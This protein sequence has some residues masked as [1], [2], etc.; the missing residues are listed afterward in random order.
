MNV[1]EEGQNG[2]RI[3]SFDLKAYIDIARP[4]H[5]FK[6]V[7]MLLG[8]VL[9]FFI[10]PDLVYDGWFTLLVL[11]LVSVCLVS[12]S[13]YVINEVLDAPRDALHPVKCRRPV[14]SGRVS[15]RVAYAEWLLLAALGLGIAWQINLPFFFSALCLWLAGMAYNIPPVRTKDVP[16]LDVLS[17]SIN[18]PLRLFMGWFVLIPHHFPPLSLVCAYW[19]VGAFFMGAKRFAEYRMI[20]NAEVAGKYRKS[21]KHYTADTLVISLFFYA[22]A[23][24]FFFGIFVIRYHLE[25]ILA[26]PVFA[27]FFAYYMKITFKKDSPVQN[28]ERLY[29]EKKFMIYLIG[30]CVIFVVLLFTRIEFMYELFNVISYKLKPLWSF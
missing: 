13:N 12:S 15:T 9:A 30:S 8:V 3:A 11:G 1:T 28:P 19:M 22:T 18:N 21:F 4:D 20:G 2:S 23:C 24:A 27:G 5:W 10:Q 26:V 7:F 14:P 17:E 16:Y 29:R 25:L 6:N